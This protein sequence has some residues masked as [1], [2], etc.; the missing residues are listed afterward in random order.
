MYHSA[1]QKTR[2]QGQDTVVRETDRET[3][4]EKPKGREE[5]Q[6]TWANEHWGNSSIRFSSVF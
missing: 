6:G 5:P 2:A 4:P 1:I 3:G